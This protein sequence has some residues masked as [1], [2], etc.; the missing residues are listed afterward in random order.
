MRLYIFDADSTLR[1]C[2]VPGQPC[3][4]K[5]GEWRLMPNV[6][7]TLKRIDWGKNGLGVASNQG[8]IALGYLTLDMAYQLCCDMVFEATGR[9]PPMGAI[10][11]CPH[12]PDAGC[13]CRKPKPLMLEKIMNVYGTRDA[14]MTGDQ[15]SD[16]V[17]AE[18]AGIEFQWAYDFFGWERV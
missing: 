7:E 14:I 10:Q 18:A 8:G 15:E 2:T 5:P 1:E 13:R 12:A 9:F 6:R 3:P 4:N 16:R 17:A 11:I